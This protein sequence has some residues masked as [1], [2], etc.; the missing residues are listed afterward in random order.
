MVKPLFFFC[1]LLF[2]LSGLAAQ[3]PNGTNGPKGINGPPNG[4][5]NP[6]GTT[7]T[8][9]TTGFNFSLN[10]LFRAA[11]ADHTVWRP[12]WPLDLPPDL[13]YISPSAMSVTVDF[14]N[15][16][17][18]EFSRNSDGKILSFPILVQQNV[19]FL[20]GRCEYDVQGR[21]LKLALSDPKQAIEA[22]NGEASNGEASNGKASG[23]PDEGLYT[24]E[25]LQWDAE[26]RPVLCRIF[27]EDY[28]FAALENS[29]G[30]MIETWYDREGKA[31]FV[32]VTGI[33]KQQWFFAESSGEESREILFF[34]NSQGLISKIEDPSAGNVSALYNH[35]KMP[36]Y[37]EQSNQSS[38]SAYTWQWNEAGRLVRFSGN[39]RTPDLDIRYEYI[40]DDRN[41]W[42]ERRESFL[43]PLNPQSSYLV[44]VQEKVIRR[45][46]DYTGNGVR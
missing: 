28:Y 20:Q 34:L 29:D 32:V 41:N 39:P 18:I 14:G 43:D 23:D 2:F 4:T 38:S 24:V 30:S 5:S 44:P 3:N 15:G 19:F 16:E 25:V 26:D 27:I 36:R 35:R 22:S 42:T 40:L 31:L 7:G 1:L 21:L 33:D 8:N 46:I 11:E 10:A 45:I 6:N 12:D 37:L 17:K 13:F 9:G